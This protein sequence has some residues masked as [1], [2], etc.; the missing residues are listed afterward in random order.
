M[1]ILALALLFPSTA[2]AAKRK[3]VETYVPLRLTTLRA[4]L[5]ST[6]TVAKGAEA[7]N[8]LISTRVT[9][10]GSVDAREVAVFVESSKGLAIPLRGPK[11]LAPGASGVYVTS[12]RL[13][14]GMV[15]KSHATA[16][17]STCRR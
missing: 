5:L 13:P 3:K 8:R 7:F 2:H 14:A 15:L 1:L 10:V 17:C 12:F 16:I 4:G 11:V 9:N 6:L